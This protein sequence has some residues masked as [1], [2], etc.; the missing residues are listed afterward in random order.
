MTYRIEDFQNDPAWFPSLGEK[1][2]KTHF[3]N[4]HYHA[5]CDPNT[6]FCEIHYDKDDPHESIE[7]FFKHMWDNKLGRSVLVIGGGAV[8]DQIFTGGK[9]RK[10]LFQLLKEIGN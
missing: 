9:V 2:D 8:L 3:R 6:R 4:G 10:F 1:T 7:S 5:E